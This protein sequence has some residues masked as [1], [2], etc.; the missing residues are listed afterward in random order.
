[1]HDA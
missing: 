1:V